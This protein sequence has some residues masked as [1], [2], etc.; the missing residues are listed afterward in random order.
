MILNV[1]CHASPTLSL[2]QVTTSPL[3]FIEGTTPAPIEFALSEAYANAPECW[4]DLVASC[5][6]TFVSGTAATIVTTCDLATGTIQLAQLQSTNIGDYTLTVTLTD[7]TYPSSLT[8]EETWSLT[9]ID[10]SACDAEELYLDELLG[11]SDSLPEQTVEITVSDPAISYNLPQYTIESI[12]A[13]DTEV[14]SLCAPIEYVL[15]VKDGS[16]QVLSSQ[17][18]ASF[19]AGTNRLTIDPL[20]NEDVGDYYFELTASLSNFPSVTETV[21]LFS[22]AIL[23]NTDPDYDPLAGFIDEE[24]I[25]GGEES[26]DADGSDDGSG[27]DTSSDT[28]DS[29][30]QDG[31]SG[32]QDDSAGSD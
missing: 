6:V 7:D 11:A 23:E 8:A 30:S 3:T 27:E 12:V 10:S 15:D 22:I 17:T 29:E 32:D 4:T 28:G 20:F 13:A 2:T 31:S 19:I 14:D 25:E 5:T 18:F 16:G 24:V 21:E 26:G 9:V 1:L